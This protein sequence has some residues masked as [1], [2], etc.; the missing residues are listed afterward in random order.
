MNG[1]KDDPSSFIIANLVRGQVAALNKI[2]EGLA[3]AA[4]TGDVALSALDKTVELLTQMK[5]KIVQAQDQSL[6]ADSITAL[7]DDVAALKNQIATIVDT[8]EFNGVNLPKPAEFNTV[9][10][11]SKNQDGDGKGIFAQ[12]FDDAGAPL[13]S[14]F[15]VTT[16]DQ[17]RPSIAALSRGGFV[18]AWE[19][20]NQDGDKDGIFAQRFDADGNAA[21]SEIQVNATTSDDQKEPAVAE[22]SGVG[23]VVTWESKNQDGDGKG[24]YAQVFDLDGAKVGSEIQVNSTTSDDQDKPAVAELSEGGFVITWESK[25]QD[26]D[27]EGHLRPALRFRRRQTRW[28]NPDQHHHVWRSEGTNRH[29]A[30]RRRLRRRLAVQEPRR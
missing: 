1:P 5:A 19:S 23:F 6:G 28:R 15:Q 14:E 13:A 9:A 16:D 7:G 21:G 10:W 12:R 3:R 22:L 20:K 26:G 8:A 24:I 2:R 18:V 25:D 11:S 29:G 4:S 27:K 17:D 30:Q